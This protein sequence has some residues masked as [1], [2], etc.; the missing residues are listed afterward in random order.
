MP[1]EQKDQQTKLLTLQGASAEYG[2]PYASLRELVIQ[3][4]LQRVQL[5]DSKRIWIRRADIE[6]L[7]SVSTSAASE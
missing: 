3:G 2:P 1:R 7:I 4:R 6:R 5:G